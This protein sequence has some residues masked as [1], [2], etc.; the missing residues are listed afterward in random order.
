MN[1]DELLERA[2]DRS[3][4]FPQL[5]STGTV[6]KGTKIILRHILEVQKS[7]HF[8]QETSVEDSPDDLQSLERNKILKS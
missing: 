4:E 7:Q 2:A 3:I 1:Y 5:D 6:S 8:D